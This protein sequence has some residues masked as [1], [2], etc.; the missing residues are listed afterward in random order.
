[1]N[2]R[3]TAENQQTTNAPT[4]AMTTGSTGELQKPIETPTL[5]TITQKTPTKSPY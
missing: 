3:P 2:N 1:M 4:T 5:Q